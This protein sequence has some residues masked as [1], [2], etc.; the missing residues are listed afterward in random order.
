MAILEHDVSNERVQQSAGGI[1][2]RHFLRLISNYNSPKRKLMFKSKLCKLSNERW[3]VYVTNCTGKIN[4]LSTLR[5]NN[6]YS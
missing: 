4:E 3:R 1:V 5:L 6:I 2:L